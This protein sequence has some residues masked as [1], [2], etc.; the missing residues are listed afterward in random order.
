MLYYILG[1]ALYLLG[2]W[3]VVKFF[4]GAAKLRNDDQGE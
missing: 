1:A 3:L 2:A 4:Q